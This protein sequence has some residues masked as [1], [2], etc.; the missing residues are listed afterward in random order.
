MRIVPIYLVFF[1]FLVDQVFGKVGF[2]VKGL[3][4]FNLTIYLLMFVWV[5]DV[6]IKKQKVFQ[7]NNVNK[8]MILMILIVLLS[9]PVKIYHGE[10]PGISIKSGIIDFKQW[11]NPILLFFI[12]FNIINDKKTCN[13]ALFGL[14]FV[15]VITI[16]LQ[17]S[18]TFGI[19][20]YAA[21]SIDKYGRAGGFSAAGV[22]AVS[23]VLLFPFAL[24]GSVL[25]KKGRLFKVGCMVLLFL[26]LMGLINAGSRNGALAFLVSMLVY[27]LILKREKIMGVLPIIF[28]IIMMVA[29]GVIAYVVSP[30]SVKEVVTERFDPTATEDLEHYSSGRLLLWGNG[31]KLFSERPLLG[32]GQDSFIILSQLRGFFYIGAPHNDYLR[33]LVEFGIVGL[34][35]FLL[36]FFKIIQ[37]AWQSLNT[38]KSP[39]EKQLYLSYISGFFGYLS[40]MFFTNMG[41]TSHIFW[42]YTALIY[43]YA[44]LDMDLKRDIPNPDKPELTIE[45]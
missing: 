7:T 21:K 14:C 30:P 4:L 19:T 16:L 17:L 22:F 35:I 24:S 27:L 12:L 13:R 23:L 18:A 34:V 39:W 44:Q 2:S 10:I 45:N 5:L 31:L 1:T 6:I 29:I 28:L 43:K 40:G 41:S 11:F 38:T 25:M 8:Y 36:I 20:H 32:H 37:N 3:S 33:C 15:F 9:I 26:M 42:I